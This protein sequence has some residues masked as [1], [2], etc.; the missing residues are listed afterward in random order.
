MESICAV[1]DA[2]GFTL[3]RDGF[4]VRELAVWNNEVKEVIEIDPCIVMAGLNKTDRTTVQFTTRN[5]HGMHHD[6]QGLDIPNNTN[7]RVIL[8]T[9]YKTLN[10]PDKPFFGIKN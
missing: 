10:R 4:L 7:M 1:V 2:Q 6:P 8:K 5:I 3:Q 9:M